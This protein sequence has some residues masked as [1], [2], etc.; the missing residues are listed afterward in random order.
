M[1]RVKNIIRGA[2]IFDCVKGQLILEFEQRI[3][4]K[5]RS[6][7]NGWGSRNVRDT[8]FGL[9]ENYISRYCEIVGCFSSNSCGDSFDGEIFK[10]KWPFYFLVDFVFD[11]DEQKLF[12]IANWRIL[13]YWTYDFK[14]EFS[15]SWMKLIVRNA[16]TIFRQII[17]RYK[18]PRKCLISFFPLTT[19]SAIFYLICMF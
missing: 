4:L 6:K 18:T 9:S 13:F 16:F 3:R 10:W 11:V 14:L 2:W 7:W 17:Y 15:Y 8:F 5:L 19:A 12:A 1:N